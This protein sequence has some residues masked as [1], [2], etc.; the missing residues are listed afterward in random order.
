M[1]ELPAD[2]CF[3]FVA[4]VTDVTEPDDADAVAACRNDVERE[5]LVERRAALAQPGT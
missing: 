3:E 1:D 5:F 4:Q 2:I